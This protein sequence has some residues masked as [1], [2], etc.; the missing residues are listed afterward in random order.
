MEDRHF[1]LLIGA[2]VVIGI[3]LLAWRYWDDMF[4]PSV[5][6]TPASVPTSAEPISAASIFLVCV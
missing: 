4:P 1:R 5:P 2:L 6:E 3:G